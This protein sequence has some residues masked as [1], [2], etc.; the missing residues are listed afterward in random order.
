ME[1]ET[2]KADER[3]TLWGK[4]SQ[5][6]YVIVLG[7]TRQL[8]RTRYPI[9]YRVGSSM[10]EAFASRSPQSDIP[11]VNRFEKVFATS[12]MYGEN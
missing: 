11:M 2:T 10:F 7:N 8:E 1:E 4:I 9:P 3:D 5:Q 6:N 12:A